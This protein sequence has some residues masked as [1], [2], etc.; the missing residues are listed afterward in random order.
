MW[1]HYNLKNK[2]KIITKKV[3]WQCEKV[4]IIR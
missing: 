2:K 4:N 3:C 1:L